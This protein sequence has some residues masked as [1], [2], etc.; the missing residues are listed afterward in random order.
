MAWFFLTLGAALFSGGAVG[1]LTGSSG[2]DPT[3]LAAVLPGLIAAGAYAVVVRQQKIS[4]DFYSRVM[5]FIMLFSGALILGV[6]YGQ[7]EREAGHMRMAKHAS[8]QNY[9]DYI[10][11]LAQCSRDE[12]YINLARESIGLEPLGSE[13]FCRAPTPSRNRS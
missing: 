3:L 4:G 5:V 2:G 10:D 7:L 9:R 1:W 8:A 11:H 13:M 12:K 6:R